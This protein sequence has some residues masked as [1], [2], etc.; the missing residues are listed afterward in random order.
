M[1]K[2]SSWDRLDVGWWQI[3][4]HLL[5][6]EAGKMGVNRAEGIQARNRRPQLDECAGNLPHHVLHRASMD[7]VLMNADA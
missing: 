4:L 7:W 2:D 3:L 6:D 5:P 1:L